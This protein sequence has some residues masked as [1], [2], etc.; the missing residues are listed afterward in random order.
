MSTILLVTDNDRVIDSVH[1]ALTDPGTKIIDE[2]D[3]AQASHVAYTEEVDAVLVD[4]RVG[5][6]GAI[7]VTHAIRNAA[8]DTD[9][10]PV[11]ILMDRDADVFLARRS[12]AAHWVKKSAPASELRRSV[13]RAGSHT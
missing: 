9:P 2:R 4:M 10:I 7:A 12:G 13:S 1:S 8:V 6:M 5:S 3:S 11:T